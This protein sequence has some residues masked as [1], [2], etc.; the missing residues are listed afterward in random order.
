MILFHFEALLH[1]NIFCKHPLYCA[2]YCTILPVIDKLLHPPPNFDVFLRCLWVFFLG[3]GRILDGS[4]C[5]KKKI[6]LDTEKGALLHI[7]VQYPPPSSPLL[8]TILRNIFPPRPPLLH[9]A[10]RKNGESG[11]AV[12]NDRLRYERHVSAVICRENSRML[13]LTLDAR[14]RAR[15]IQRSAP[16]RSPVADSDTNP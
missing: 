11:W 10:A 4:R 3:G 1:N 14:C 12:I 16:Q 2:I 8:P 9:K 5:L 6:F 13:G 7:I 15:A